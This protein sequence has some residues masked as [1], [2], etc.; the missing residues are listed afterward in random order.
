MEPRRSA[1]LKALRKNIT[2]AMT[3]D[4]PPGRPRRRHGHR[5][6]RAHVRQAHRAAC[7]RDR[8]FVALPTW[9][10]FTINLPFT[11]LAMVAGDPIHVPRDAD[12]DTM[13]AY[14]QKVEAAMNAA[15]ERA[16]ELAGSD[17]RKTAPKPQLPRRWVSCFRFTGP[18]TPAARPAAMAILRRRAARGKEVPARLPERL[19]IAS[20]SRPEGPLFWFHAASVGETNAVLPLMHE[21]KRRCPSLNILLTTVTVTSSKIAAERLPQGAIHQ[22]MPLDSPRFCRASSSIGALHLALFTE[23]LKSGRT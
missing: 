11:K 6:A 20:V 8:R 4:I 1:A 9:S 12:E 14:R 13:E 10:R 23:F 2:V 22:F 5:H 19:G 15:T 18:A 3:S 21:L 7:N 17:A 16:Y